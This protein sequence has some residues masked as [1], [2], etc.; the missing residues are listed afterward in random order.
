MPSTDLEARKAKPKAKPYRLSFGGG[1]LLEVRPSKAD[2][3][4][5]TKAWLLRAQ[6]N[7]KRRDVGLGGYPAVTL[8]AARDKAKTL[9]AGKA[10]KR[11]P[12]V[13]KREAEVAEKARVAAME[14]AKAKALTF[15]DV[16]EEL[17]KVQRDAWSSPKTEASWRLTFD[18]WLL[19][20]LG[21][22]PVGEV[23][24]EHVIRALSP[25]W[26]SKPATAVKAQRRISAVLDYAAAQGLRAADNPAAGRVLRLTR[27]LPRVNM[28]GK[29][30]ASLPW[31]K[32]PAFYA[33][34]SRMEGISPLALRMAV[35]T[36]LRSNEIRQM[37][38]GDVDFGEELIV[39]PAA[40]MKGGKAGKAADHRLPV[41]E[42]MHVVLR[43]ALE[44]ATGESVQVREVPARAA[45]LR[46]TLVFPNSNGD[47]L[48]DAALGAVIKRLNS[49]SEDGEFPL[50][51]DLDGRS[52]TAHGFRR[53][54]RTW[55]DDER[56]QDAAA[57]E[58]QLAHEDRNTVA[59]AYRGGDLIARRRDLMAAWGALVST[60]PAAKVTRISEARVR[61]KGAA[62]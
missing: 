11:D 60:P 50:W 3:E 29:R 34:V 32:V 61:R 41:T 22:V 62:A 52:A 5:G 37:L 53:S 27:A 25:I 16:A 59:A 7:G 54:F 56:P 30:Q 38:W 9:L 43:A 13:V 19:P 1:L 23:A 42:A 24:K 33:V 28:A 36:A 58:K 55:V 49:G 40:R 6:V 8:A 45:L 15:R 39:L 48:S 26:T 21:K 17:L 51:C 14:E 35:L 31:P 18:N 4:R 44:F 10:D 20:V 12:L 2:P 57:A 47:A 46:D